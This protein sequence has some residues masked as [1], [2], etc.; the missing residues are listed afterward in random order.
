MSKQRNEAKQEVI[1]SV[2]DRHLGKI[3]EVAKRLRKA[4]LEV[5]DVLEATGTI[6]GSAAPSVGCSGWN[7]AVP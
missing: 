4:G 7:D 3:R 5:K 2:S 1:I 6:T